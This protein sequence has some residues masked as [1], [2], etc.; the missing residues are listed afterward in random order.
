MAWIPRW[1]KRL[2]G[3]AAPAPRGSAHT[4][5][6]EVTA[7]RAAAGSPPTA[8]QHLDV[9]RVDAAEDGRALAVLGQ[10]RDE[11]KSHHAVQSE[12]ANLIRELHAP[13]RALPEL[14]RQQGGLMET[15]VDQSSRS[16]TRDQ[17]IERSLHQLTEGAA[18]QTQVLGLVQQQLDLNHE[19]SIRVSDSL[20]DTA[21]ALGAFAATT[22]RQ[23]RA[24]EA[25]AESTRSRLAQSERLER[26]LQFWLLVVSGLATL[27]LLY[28]LWAAMRVPP[29]PPARPEVVADGDAAGVRAAG[30]GSTAVPAPEPASPPSTAASAPAAGASVPSSDGARGAQAPAVPARPGATPATSPSVPA[31]TIP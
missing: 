26:T 6:A 21:S 1:L 10:F 16:R 25:L 28:A 7:D 27:I 17:A 12:L 31:S 8:V 19:T 3:I 23:T 13:M 14:A 29:T 20:R 24:L 2:L 11:L 15:L 18:R 9:S 5:P 30:T 4:P 22:D